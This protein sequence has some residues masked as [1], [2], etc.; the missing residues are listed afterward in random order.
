M[1]FEGCALVFVANAAGAF[2]I[3]IAPFS[4]QQ[5]SASP[6]IYYHWPITH[7]PS[8]T[9]SGFSHRRSALCERK[10]T[11][12]FDSQ[13]L[14]QQSPRRKTA[15]QAAARVRQNKFKHLTWFIF[16]REFLWLSRAEKITSAELRFFYLLTGVKQINRIM[17]YFLIWASLCRYDN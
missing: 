6:A 3:V 1:H 14:F 16:M 10:L 17:V 4:T 15:F 7:W 9:F 11:N 8:H 2:F 12:K 5:P 13:R